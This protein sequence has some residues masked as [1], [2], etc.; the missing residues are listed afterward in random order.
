[1]LAAKAQTMVGG[2]NT[3]LVIDDPA[4]LKQGTRAVGV[5]RRAGR[6]RSH[7]RVHAPRMARGGARPGRR[8]R[9][10]LLVLLGDVARARSDDARDNRRRRARRSLT[11]SAY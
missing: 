5:D 8:E 9:G 7:V 4:P 6:R 10:R 1:V 3:V 2:P 11:P